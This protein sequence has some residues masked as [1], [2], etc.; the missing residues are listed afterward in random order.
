MTIQQKLDKRT[1]VRIPFFRHT[2]KIIV[3]YHS[4]TFFT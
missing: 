4:P 3:D 2:Y 1:A